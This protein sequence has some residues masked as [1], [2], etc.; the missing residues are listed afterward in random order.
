MPQ[1]EYEPA[2]SADS[3]APARHRGRTP[4]DAVARALGVAREQV[5]VSAD[6]D[7][8]GWQAVS[9]DGEPAGRIRDHAARM[10]FR[11]D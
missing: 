7:D 8:H 3:A 10:R 1:Y 4:A 11:R 9:V 2:P 6:A 5:D